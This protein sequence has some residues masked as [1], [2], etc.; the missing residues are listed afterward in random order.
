MTQD[1]IFCKIAAGD[2]PA[3]ILY[4]DERA[5][6]FYDIDP[7]APSHVLLI[8]VQHVES[9]AATTTEHEPLLGHLL[10][11]APRVAALAG[12]DRSGYRTVVNTGRDAGM[13]VYH[14]HLHVLGGRPMAWPPG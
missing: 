3:K 9:L 6:A 7:K 11:L 13:A 4:R 5:I 10:R 8:P 12:I 14:L 1:C 2:I